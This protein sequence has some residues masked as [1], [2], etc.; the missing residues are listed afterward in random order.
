MPIS[1]QYRCLN[2]GHRFE[3]R[4]LTEEEAREARRR[5]ERLSAVHCPRCN[6]TDIRKGW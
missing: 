5:N 6:R 3:T 2:C 1:V 4:A